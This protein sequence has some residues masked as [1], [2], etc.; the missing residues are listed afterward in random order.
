MDQTRTRRKAGRPRVNMEGDGHGNPTLRI[1]LPQETMSR[2]K[3]AGGSPWARTVIEEALSRL[4][5]H[6]QSA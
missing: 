3:A 4:G 5:K 1:R 6:D 2:V